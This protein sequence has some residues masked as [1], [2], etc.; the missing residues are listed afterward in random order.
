MP[1]RQLIETTESFRRYLVLDHVT[2][3]VVGTDVEAIPTPA[4]VNGATLRGRVATALTTNTTYLALPAPRTNAQVA[5]QV[6]ALTRQ[7]AA[8]IRLVAGLLATTDGT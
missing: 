8:L 2:N 5:A 4:Q 6:E 3:Q 7:N 1:T